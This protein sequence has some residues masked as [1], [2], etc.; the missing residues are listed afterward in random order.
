ME[1]INAI[2]IPFYKFQSEKELVEKIHEDVSKL[3]YTIENDITNGYVYADYYH[4]ELFE[5]FDQ[6][7][8]QV[9]KLYYYD[10]LSFPIVDCW[11]NKYTSLNKLNR[12]NHSNST[13]CGCYYITDHD[14][15]NTIFEHHN[16]WNFFSSGS[17]FNLQIN[18]NM[19][20]LEGEIKPIAGTLI[21]F[22]SNL[23]HRMKVFKDTKKTRYTV[24]FNTFPSGIVSDLK[25]K[26]LELK[27]YSLEERIKLGK[28]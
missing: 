15:G 17:N 22:P 25:T 19:N 12:H 1:K 26:K 18:K 11:A 7:I 23:Y 3:Q 10:T 14:T 6:C 8:T 13:I 28:K 24:A 4:K 5:W 2:N 21:L 27:S 9:A 16:P 20:P